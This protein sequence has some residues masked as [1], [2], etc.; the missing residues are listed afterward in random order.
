MKIVLA[1]FFFFFVCTLLAGSP[2]INRS[3]LL[4]DLQILSGDDMQGR[5]AGTEGAAKARRYIRERF[6]E[7]GLPPY[8][9][10]YEQEFQFAYPKE[11][12]ADNTGTNLVAKIPG[13]TVD[14]I[15]AITAHYDHLGI[16]NG[17]VYNGADDNASGVA[18]LLALSAYFLEHP[19]ENTFVIAALDS[20]EQSSRGSAKFVQSLA[21]KKLVMNVNLDMIGRDAKNILYAVGTYHYPCLSPYVQE[22]A[23]SAPVT[24]LAGHDRPGQK[25]VE[26]WTKESD[27]Y[28]FYKQG[29]PFLYFGVEDNEHHHRPTDDY[30]NM[31]HDFFVNAVATIIQVVNKLDQN[32]ST[33]QSAISSGTCKSR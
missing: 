1:F 12:K 27:H 23:A 28:A 2:E 10:K 24:L 30:E 22:I 4:R 16:R 21:R 11:T 18:G 6:E 7:S 13:K 9:K 8:E 14:R 3:Q 29:I 5:K 19:P 25:D 17:V 32:L 33:I 31:T 20:E 26:D 15:L